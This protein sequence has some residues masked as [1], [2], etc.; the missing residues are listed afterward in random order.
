MSNDL[1]VFLHL[2]KTAGTTLHHILNSA[3]GERHYRIP[4]K[5]SLQNIQK[6]GIGVDI[7]KIDCVSGHMPYGI[8]KFIDRDVKYFT[9]LRHPA[10]RLRSYYQYVIARGKKHTLF[11]IVGKMTFEQF[12]MSDIATVDNGMTRLLSG[13]DNYGVHKI[14]RKVKETDFQTALNNL[15][16][17]FFVGLQE[18][19]SE[20]VHTL[21]DLLKIKFDKKLLDE[22]WLYTGGDTISLRLQQEI[23]DRND[24][25]MRLYL[26][27][28]MRYGEFT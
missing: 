6:N 11:K 7:N 17:M 8:H 26:Q 12:I 5:S 19:F 1:I 24:Y 21:A 10:Y 4:N 13:M 18:A 28:V 16:G 27:A 23:A 25:D 3:Y 22:K 15:A 2:P 14:T 9:F 20:S